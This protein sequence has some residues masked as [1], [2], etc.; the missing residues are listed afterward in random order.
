MVKS[1]QI[2]FIAM[3]LLSSF[4]HAKNLSKK[5]SLKIKN[6][7]SNKL[8]SS[9]KIHSKDL[10]DPY[11]TE[12]SFENNKLIVT[13]DEQKAEVD[14]SQKLANND[15]NLEINEKGKFFETCIDCEAYSEEIFDEDFYYVACECSDNN[16]NQKQT[17]VQVNP[18]LENIIHRY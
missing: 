2:I 17:S 5:A 12:I 16:H 6:N 18:F 4:I 15:G 11:C 10:F 9:N 14:L 1:S 3:M 7:I 8:K 13:C